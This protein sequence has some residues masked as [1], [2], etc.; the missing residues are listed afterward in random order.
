MLVVVDFGIEAGEIEAVGQ[1]FFVDLTEV[2]V[3]TRRD[4]LARVLVSSG[5]SIMCCTEDEKYDY[6]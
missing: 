6:K 4:E 1:V 5:G 2:F 3:A